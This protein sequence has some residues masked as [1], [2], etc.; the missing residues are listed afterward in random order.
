MKG[1]KGKETSCPCNVGT[2]P[3]VIFWLGVLTG[4]LVLGFVFFYQA[5]QAEDYQSSIL[6]L[7]RVSKPATTLETVTTDTTLVDGIGG[8]PGH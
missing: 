5:M 4:A 3:M 6:K 8:G 2:H 1:T 7:F